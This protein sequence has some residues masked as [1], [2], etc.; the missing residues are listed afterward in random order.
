MRDIIALFPERLWWL[1]LA[2]ILIFLF[3]RSYR[4]IQQ[5]LTLLGISKPLSRHSVIFILA[6][7]CCCLALTEPIGN[8]QYGN[9][10]GKADLDPLKIV[11][12]IDDSLSMTTT[13]TPLNLS[14]LDD[15]KRI[16]NEINL[17]LPPHITEVYLFTSDLFQLV[18]ETHDHLFVKLML[19]QI[20]SDQTLARGTNLLSVLQTLDETADAIILLSDGEDQK[21]EEEA[22]EEVRKDLERVLKNK[23]PFY[24]I[25]IGSHEGAPIPN[26]TYEGDVVISSLE[27]EPLKQLS[28]LTN[29]H[30]Y[31]ANLYP[32]QTLSQE[33]VQ[34]IVQNR[35]VPVQAAPP[36]ISATHLFQ[37][38]LFFA[39]LFLFRINW[40]H[41]TL[42]LCCLFI[43]LWSALPEAIELYNRGVKEPDIETFE[44]VLLAPIDYPPLQYRASVNLALLEATPLERA[45]PLFCL[46]QRLKG[47]SSCIPSNEL[48]T[49]WAVKHQTERKWV[50][51]D[52]NGADLASAWLSL[53]D[54][55]PEGFLTPQLETWNTWL[56]NRDR[57][58]LLAQISA[59]DREFETLD[60]TTQLKVLVQRFRFLLDQ[61]WRKETFSRLQ[62]PLKLGQE[63]LERGITALTIG[64]MKSAD[65][66][67]HLSQLLLEQQMKPET[68]LE[69]IDS[70]IRLH[71][72]FLSLLDKNLSLSAPH[73]LPL[74]KQEE[75]F[76]P[77]VLAWQMRHTDQCL[78]SPWSLV[79]PLFEEGQREAN[80]TAHDLTNNNAV[81]ALLHE[82]RLIHAW[83]KARR[84][85]ANPPPPAPR[86]QA[87][88]QLM[89][90]IEEMDL[91]DRLP[92][93]SRPQPT[94]TGVKP[95]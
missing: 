71:T 54:A 56:K 32:G 85:I 73:Y 95:W 6:W 42:F 81:S 41:S 50:V 11:Y 68:P 94:Q 57:D 88:E 17:N 58:R 5:R 90:R 93:Q 23:T 7:I 26:F 44:K 84:L 62:I 4:I 51:D 12:M 34:Q 61:P 38:P 37:I 89:Q 91:D 52:F 3:L 78:K 28:E 19:D 8:R 16:A 87:P 31:Q 92:D 14:R 18:P 10:Q 33:L 63:A 47:Y 1:L 83:T 48:L 9:T 27:P 43:P 40:R 13:D 15:A 65:F 22:Q 67:L 80:A 45:L 69:I 75:S 20:T 82:E 86:P 39:L 55:P 53:P 59:V 21:L 36:L 29:G 49:L 66:E 79:F 25:G 64:D 60:E 46:E 76:T 30:Y 72:L 35:Q 24:T 77:A 70:L 2:L 74:R